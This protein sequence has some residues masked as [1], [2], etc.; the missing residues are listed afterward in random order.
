M[1]R[2]EFNQAA[3]AMAAAALTTT[4]CGGGGGAGPAP[5]AAT[6]PPSASSATGAGAGSGAGATSATP[7]RLN[8]LPMGTNLS[9]MEWAKPGL[10][11]G[12]STLP[13]LNFSVPRAADV[14][15]LASQ[16]FN[17]NRLPIQWE[18]LQPVLNDSPANAAVQALLGA[19]GALH[20]GYAAYITGVLDAHAAAG[21]RCI[22]DC[23]NYGRY[24]DFVYQADG[25]VIGLTAAST[26]LIRPFTTDGSQVIERILSLAP[27]AT[28]TVGNFTDF[29]TRVARQWKD[30]PG[31]GGYGLMNEPHDLPAAGGT[32]ASYGNQDPTIW[33]AFAQAAINAIR[34]VDPNGAIY[35]AGN[36]W[37]AAMTLATNNPAW[38]LSGSNLVY[39]VHMYL[40]ASCSGYAFDYD[41]EVAKG[42]SAGLSGPINLDT[43]VNRLQLAVNWAKAQG[44][45]LALTEVGMPVDDP[46]WQEMFRRAVAYAVANQVEVYSW[47][48]G[49]HWPAHNYAINH[50]PGWHQNRTLE[51]AVAGPMK[52]AVGLASA[53]VFDDGPGDASA[54]PVTVTVY[55]RGNL[56]APLVLQVASSN[57]GSFSK[58]TLTIPAGANGQDSYTFTPP[59]NSVST[60]SYSSDGQLGGQVPPPRKVYALADPVAYAATSLADAARALLAK[61]NA[62]KWELA[63]GYTDYLL[64]VP[65]AEGQ[66][67]RAVADS[68]YGSS[69][70][71]AMEMINWVNKEMGDGGAMTFPVMRSVNGKPSSDHS[72]PQTFG[73][74]CKK[75]EPI[76]GV[77]AN[78]LNRTPYDLQDPHFAI[79]AISVPTAGNSGVVFQASQAQAS[80]AAE[81]ALAGGQPQARWTD[82]NGQSVAITAAASLAPGQ[83]AVIAMSSA[84]GAQV[85]RVNAQVAGTAAAT[86]APSV[87]TQL[88]LGW[89]F[90]DYYPRDG[91]GG[92]LFAAITGRGT[93]T[94]AEMAVMER[95]LASTAGLSI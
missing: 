88:L 59:P 27:G 49:N 90:V 74:W 85:L 58:T 62:S 21:T 1:K 61:Y 26:P 20:A 33:A 80:H 60:L 53:A 42:F 72:A 71:N 31:F 46:R 76:P 67:L 10:R 7:V 86:L 2:R 63:Q 9:G 77:Q 8:G 87:T 35:L 52:A 23:H 73:L 5:I 91:F 45:K 82:A 24:Q 12:M 32:T 81:L 44:V 94:A 78:P 89:G 18:L 29:W 43:G 30:H 38:P 83:P 51:P 34:A 70:G 56:A 84:P 40:D 64:G 48:G 79:A 39:E 68:G 69:A 36:D 28:L 22:I 47:M 14:A 11:Y 93:P 41:T 95:Y 55:V 25:S 65:A 66:P 17:K 4:A 16:G 37:E 3:G 75:S 54:G 57:G 6:N 50:V 13:N 92:N 15:Y 19:P